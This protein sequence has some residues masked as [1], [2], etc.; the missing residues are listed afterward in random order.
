MRRFE[1]EV[2]ALNVRVCDRLTCLCFLAL[3]LALV[4]VGAFALIVVFADALIGDTG[5][6]L[7][8]RSRYSTAQI[9]VIN[10]AAMT[11]SAM[12]SFFSDK[13]AHFNRANVNHHTRDIEDVTGSHVALCRC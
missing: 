7:V 3:T 11:I 6:T 9:A 1:P 4:L 8:P 2:G 13:T 10:T 12:V 5:T